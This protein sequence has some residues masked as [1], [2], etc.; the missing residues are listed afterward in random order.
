MGKK[1]IEENSWGG[2]NLF[3]E[4]VADVVVRGGGWGG[5]RKKKKLLELAY[6]RG[7]TGSLKEL[8]QIYEK[9]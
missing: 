7:G 4:L 2:V 1:A 3:R 8:K 6:F 5:R 9:S